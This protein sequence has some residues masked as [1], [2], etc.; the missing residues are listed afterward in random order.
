MDLWQSFADSQPEKPVFVEDG[1]EITLGPLRKQSEILCRR[2]AQMSS[3][4]V[5]V[6]SNRPSVLAICLLAA[7][8]S[9]RELLIL[10][11]PQA[12]DSDFWRCTRVDSVVQERDLELVRTGIAN[13]TEPRNAAIL[14]PT[15]GTSGVPKIARHQISGLMSRIRPTRPPHGPARWLLT[16]QPNGF[17]GIQMILTALV[18]DST[19]VCLSETDVPRLTATALSQRVTHISGTPTFWRS[20]LLCLGE[21]VS[22]TRRSATDHARRGGGGSGNH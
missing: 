11:A 12:L 20:F 15:S 6:F 4:R 17:A 10:R 16:Y 2:L 7:V 19:L 14:I 8:K 3:G 5:A 21:S 1:T 9:G 22:R 18:T 13:I